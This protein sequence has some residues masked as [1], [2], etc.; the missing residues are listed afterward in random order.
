MIQCGDGEYC[1]FSKKVCQLKFK[2]CKSEYDCGV[3]K[4]CVK[5]SKH[6]NN[7]KCEWLDYGGVAPPFVIHVDKKPEKPHVNPTKPDVNVKPEGSLVE[8]KCDNCSK[9]FE[10]DDK[11]KKCVKVFKKCNPM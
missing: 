1:S 11:T 8:R 3:N 2:K 6:N 4:T 10:C 9:G 7:K 5:Y